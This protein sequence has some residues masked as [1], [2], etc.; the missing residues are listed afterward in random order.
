MGS[1]QKGCTVDNTYGLF[2]TRSCYTSGV[3]S[4]GASGIGSSSSYKEET[5]VYHSNTWVMTT[6]A[7]AYTGIPKM[8]PTRPNSFPEVKRTN[9]IVTGWIDNSFPRTNGEIKR[10]SMVCSMTKTISTWISN[11]GKNRP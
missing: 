4:G 10:P 3:F 8:T 7:A 5:R 11:T 6:L 1:L 9:R 2:Y